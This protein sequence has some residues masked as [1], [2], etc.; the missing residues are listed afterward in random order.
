MRKI[1]L[2][3]IGLGL[4]YGTGLGLYIA[5]LPAPFTTLPPNLEGLAAFTGGAGRVATTLRLVQQGF[6]GPVLISG[7][8]P[9]TGLADIVAQSGLPPLSTAQREQV[10]LD[11]AASTRENMESLTL[12]ATTTNLRE[13]GVITSTYHAARVKLLGWWL[14]P[15]LH[16]TLLPV[17]PEDT[18][19]TVLVREYNKLLAAPFLR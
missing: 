7:I 15:D 16:L 9:G 12:W 5:L 2:G 19:L 10:M 11:G 17:Q 8:N 4:A 3:G 14:A 6:Q 1:L 18:R 13:V